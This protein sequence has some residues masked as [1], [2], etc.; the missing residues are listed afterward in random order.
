[1]KTVPIIQHFEAHPSSESVQAV[2]RLAKAVRE[3][4]PELAL[5]TSL[6][7][8]SWFFSIGSSGKCCGED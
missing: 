5:P 3:E 7:T 8:C 1:M 2:E 4:R 6:T